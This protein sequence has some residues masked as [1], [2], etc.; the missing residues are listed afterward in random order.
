[1]DHPLSEDLETSDSVAYLKV[2][3]SE[4]KFLEYDK[5]LLLT[6]GNAHPDCFCREL[7]LR[8]GHLLSQ[9]FHRR[10]LLAS[11]SPFILSPEDSVVRDHGVYGCCLCGIHARG[12]IDRES[13]LRQL[14]GS[15][16]FVSL[17]DATPNHLWMKQ[18]RFSAV[19]LRMELL[20]RSS[21]QL[22]LEFFDGPSS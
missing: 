5:V 22:D 13:H 18:D 7:L 2:S 16:R 21:R 10:L 3:E 19:G 12:H 20:R 17:L 4:K 9:S 1:M 6:G 11:H 8:C 15:S 14:V